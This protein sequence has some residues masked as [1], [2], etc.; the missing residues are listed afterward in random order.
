M[1]NKSAHP[2]WGRI[3]Q[4]CHWAMD[5][6]CIS[7]STESRRSYADKGGDENHVKGLD[8]CRE[9]SGI[10][11]F[12]L[13]GKSQPKYT[14]AIIPVSCK[15]KKLKNGMVE[16]DVRK[17]RSSVLLKE[18]EKYPNNLRCYYW[19]SGMCREPVFEAFVED[20]IVDCNL[21]KDLE[22]R[23]LSLDWYD[24]HVHRSA[25]CKLYSAGIFA[26]FTENDCT[27]IL[28]MPDGGGIKTLKGKLTELVEKTVDENVDT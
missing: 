17:P 15:S 12:N 16:F 9:L 18:A 2:V 5:K 24:S 26:I 3:L 20:F 14:Y 4:E 27:D 1:Y 11:L 19:P 23:L 28:A 10:A 6:F 22:D 21:D 25:L 13:V 8:T 7:L